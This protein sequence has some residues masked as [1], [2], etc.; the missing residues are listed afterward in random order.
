M[1]SAGAL[2]R[3]ICGT[4]EVEREVVDRAPGMPPLEEVEEEKV[5]PKL[6]PPMGRLA[7]SMSADQPLRGVPIREGDLWHLST[8]E[9]VDQ[10]R[11]FLHVN[12][13]RFFADGQEVAIS[14]S[15]FTLVRNCKF[16]STQA[17]MNFSEFKIFKISLFAQGA[18]YY[19]GLRGS[20]E[21]DAEEERSRWVLDVSRITRLV[22]QSL[23]PPFRITCDPIPCS[24]DL[25]ELTKGRLMA[26]YLVHYDD[27]F[28]ASVL[29]C[30][31]HVNR[32]DHA[33]FIFYEDETCAHQLSE[34]YV[35]ERSIC[36]E[37]IGINC[38]CF[39]VEEHQFSARSLAERKLWLRAISNLKVKLQNG[40][41]PPSEQEVCHYRAAIKEHVAKI[42][43]LYDGLHSVGG[44][45][46]DALLQRAAAPAW[47]DLTWGDAGDG[48]RLPDEP[49]PAACGLGLAEGPVAPAVAGAA[50]VKPYLPNL[51]TLPSPPSPMDLRLSERATRLLVGPLQADEHGADAHGD[52]SGVS[53]ASARL[54]RSSSMT[55]PQRREEHRGRE[56]S[57]SFEP[58]P[59]P[60]G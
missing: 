22:T 51:G 13:F 38:S 15:P 35:T 11:V 29:Y 23:F 40:A 47:Q 43:G 52:A 45:Q 28:T 17:G 24:A 10:V 41:P 59:K 36:C 60:E 33:R 49:N 57:K 7:Y 32:Q 8:E 5:L 37:K 14:L 31:L 19:F 12:G 21:R 27:C 58:F 53:T 44:L 42:H 1:A 20:C 18:C 30:E 26:G 56:R 34:M 3:C 9:K 25:H 4:S 55:E 6:P 50:V 39:S 48:E 16:Q 2:C 46:T 54:Q